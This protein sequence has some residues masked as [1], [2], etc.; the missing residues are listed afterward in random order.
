VA[1]NAK[2]ARWRPHGQPAI[3]SSISGKIFQFD[4]AVF[5]NEVWIGNVIPP[6]PDQK[7]QAI[8]CAIPGNATYRYD[9]NDSMML[10]DEFKVPWEGSSCTTAR[11]FCRPAANCLK[12]TRDRGV[13]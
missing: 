7:K 3:R 6:A 13:R 11:C 9:E 5:A 2:G 1:P 4:G 10:C 8:T 12:E